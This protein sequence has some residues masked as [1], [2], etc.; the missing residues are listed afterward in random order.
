M[1]LTANTSIL[2]VL[3]QILGNYQNGFSVQIEMYLNSS[4]EEFS[5]SNMMS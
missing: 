4:Q 2:T 3:S 5:L 1:E